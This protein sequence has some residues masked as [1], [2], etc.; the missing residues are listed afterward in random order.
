[1]DK[2][3]VQE[4]FFISKVYSLR[5][6]SEQTK[7]EQTTLRLYSVGA[8]KVPSEKNARKNERKTVVFCIYYNAPAHI[9]L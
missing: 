2:K 7:C 9:H 5:A 4:V 6:H 3:I 8:Y 1:M